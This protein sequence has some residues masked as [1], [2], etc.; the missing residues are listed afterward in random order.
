[1]VMR[2]HETQ[3]TECKKS[4]SLMKEGLKS[5]CAML[6]ADTGVGTV[7]FGVGPD[8]EVAGLEGDSDSMQRT[9]SDNIRQ[10]FDPVPHVTIVR[11]EVDGKQILIVKASRPRSVVL[12]EYDG[13]A[14]LRV[15]SEQRQLTLAD[16]E[17]LNVRRNRDMHHGPWQCDGCGTIVMHGIPSTVISNLGIS[18]T[19]DHHACGGE[20]WP[21]A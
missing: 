3:D 18:K 13:R 4:L 11:E 8:G 21:L 19:Y 9:L 5:L 12:Y 1:M 6:N 16:R 2:W 15:G 20:F 17:Q 7:V 10:K 14:Y